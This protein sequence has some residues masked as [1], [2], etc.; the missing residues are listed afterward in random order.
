MKLPSR[1]MIC[2]AFML[3]A[4]CVR[5]GAAAS[6]R[7]APAKATPA[8]PDAVAQMISKAL[9]AAPASKAAA[10][11]KAP[12]VAGQPVQ[13]KKLDFGFSDFESK[14]TSAVS[15]KLVQTATGDAWND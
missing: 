8:V 10:P 11:Q 9:N 6:L 5:S 15:A 12:A 13:H 1:Q 14:L 3:F 4:S 7:A 2:L